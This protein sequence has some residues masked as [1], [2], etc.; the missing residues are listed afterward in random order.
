MDNLKVFVRM[1]ARAYRYEDAEQELI[2]HTLLQI[3]NGDVWNAMF[4]I[5]KDNEIHKRMIEVMVEEMGFNVEEFKE[6][7]ARSVEIDRLEISDDLAVRILNELLKYEYWAKNYYEN[8]I[9][10]IG[11]FLSHELGEKVVERVIKDL[12]RL[13]E[14]EKNHIEKIEDLIGKV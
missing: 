6:Y 14:W 8:M 4:D 10:L 1:L 12:E 5:M 9:R 11:P 3:T 13:T 2:S 7:S